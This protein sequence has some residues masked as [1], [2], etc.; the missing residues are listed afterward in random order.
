M[1]DLESAS[2]VVRIVP[3][4]TSVRV[5][6]EVQEYLEKVVKSQGGVGMEEENYLLEMI[7]IS[8]QAHPEETGADMIAVERARQVFEKGYTNAHDD[9]WVNG[10]LASA[11]ARYALVH[12][13]EDYR[14]VWWP[15]LE[16]YFH[17]KDPI[18]NLVRAGAFIAAEID[19]LRRLKGDS[20]VYF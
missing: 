13:S 20:H 18:Y 11:G 1:A 12:S 3:G 14:K 7:S 9:K 17:P 8:L 19:R 2:I 4:S 15:F 6:R 5:M 10:E 16:R